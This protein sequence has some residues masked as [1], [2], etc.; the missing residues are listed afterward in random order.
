MRSTHAFRA[1]EQLAP[2]QQI[3][4]RSLSTATSRN[5]RRMVSIDPATEGSQGD[6]AEYPL[7][8][9]GEASFFISDM[10]DFVQ[11]QTMNKMA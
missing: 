1:M 9:Y 7:N 2:L 11:I 8:G 10:P 5:D 3:R 4:A 6:G